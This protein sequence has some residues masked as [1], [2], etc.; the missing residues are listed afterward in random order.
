MSFDIFDL[1]PEIEKIVDEAYNKKRP[2][3][4]TLKE[5]NK[6]LGKKVLPSYISIRPV[7]PLPA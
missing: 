5:F 2:A 3:L 7:I 4:E 6:S 1:T